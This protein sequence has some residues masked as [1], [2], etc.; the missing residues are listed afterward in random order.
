[1]TQSVIDKQWKMLAVD[2][3][4]TDDSVGLRDKQPKK[5]AVYNTHSSEVD[6]RQRTTEVDRR[7]T[8]TEVDRRQTTTEVDHRQTTTE[9]GR[10][11]TTTEVDRRQTALE[12]A[13]SRRT[14]PE[15]VTQS[16][17][18][19]LLQPVVD[20][21]PQTQRRQTTQEI[22]TPDSATKNATDLHWK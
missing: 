11:Q 5:L 1:M 12:S 3:C 7:Q 20:K 14:H 8:T 2:S 15:S 13:G 4:K 16:P 9:V 10:R 19:K 18:D 21:Q 6:R 22:T 17:A